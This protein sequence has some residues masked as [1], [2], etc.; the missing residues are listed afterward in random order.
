[1]RTHV[2]FSI[3]LDE[4]VAEKSESL[5]QQIQQVDRVVRE[6]KDR[7]ERRVFRDSHDLLNSPFNHRLVNKG[8]D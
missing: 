5:T 6:C 4:T 7:P 1:M 2:E 8:P 3:E